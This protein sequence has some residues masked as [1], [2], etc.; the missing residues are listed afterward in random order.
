VESDVVWAVEEASY[1][2]DR[3]V[4][5]WEPAR[6]QF[7]LG[8]TNFAFLNAAFSKQQNG[9]LTPDQRMFMARGALTHGVNH[10]F[11]W[12]GLEKHT[13]QT[14][15]IENVIAT[16]EQEVIERMLTMLVNHPDQ[17]ADFGQLSSLTMSKLIEFGMESPNPTLKIK[18]LEFIGLI[19]GQNSKWENIHFSASD[20]TDIAT[21]A[22]SD[23]LEIAKNAAQIIG[24]TQSISAV[25]L[26]WKAVNNGRAKD[27][28]RVLGEIYQIAGSLPR[29]LS[30]QARFRIW[31]ELVQK[32]M[33]KDRVEVLRAL[34]FS[35]LA[36]AL[37]IGIHSYVGLRLP[38]LFNTAR[39]LGSL[40]SG[41]VIGPLI[42]LGF[43]FTRWF[44]HRFRVLRKPIRTILGVLIGGLIISM[45]IAIYH[46]LFLDSSPQGWLIVLGSMIIIVGFGIGSILP[47]S[48]IL[49]PV[50]SVLSSGLGL[51]ISWF[52]AFTLN[53]TPMLYYESDQPGKSIIMIITTALIFGVIPYLYGTLKTDDQN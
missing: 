23:N 30:S 3:F 18:A 19:V 40:G 37:G 34:G 43:F 52:Y 27:G 51:G 2:Y 1:I 36:G 53:Q 50:L 14:K 7:K 21:L 9:D 13:A 6:E 8:L 49:P 12:R 28:L 31:L 5:F 41:L 15:V 32:F 4:Q 42:G 11:W 47:T 10:L 25:K 46:R 20:D 35:I 33:L 16:E 26:L 24:K 38:S 45:S 29:T 22:L 44:I 48:K 17:L 39:I